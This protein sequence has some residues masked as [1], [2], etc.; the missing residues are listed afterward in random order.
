M[1]Q[2][3]LVRYAGVAVVPV[4]DIAFKGSMQ[5]RAFVEA[6]L[7]AIMPEVSRL[8]ATKDG[9]ASNRIL[10]IY[11]YSVKLVLFAG[12]PVFILGILV[13]S[14]T[15]VLKLWLG[16][17]FV[18]ELPAAVSVMLFG[19]FLG[20]LGVPAYYTL[21]GLGRVRKTFI[22]HTVV[23]GMN[24][25]ILITVVL[26]GCVKLS[27]SMVAWA[28]VAGT[29]VSTVYLL[30]EKGR[31]LREAPLLDETT[32]GLSVQNGPSGNDT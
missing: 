31:S 21:I 10:K 12:V 27:V 25:G 23:S 28:F 5:V 26:I 18:G 30:W 32:E 29:G 7:R 15:P 14:Y 2:L 4:Y 8:G 1:I 6:A 13:I 24:A 19:T 17:K 9:V 11:K 16:S 22:A 3:M 20:L